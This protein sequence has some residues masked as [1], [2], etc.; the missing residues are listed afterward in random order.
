MP[1]QLGGGSPEIDSTPVPSLELDNYNSSPEFQGS[2]IPIVSTQYSDFESLTG[3]LLAVVDNLSEASSEYS[4]FD[5]DKETIAAADMENLPQKLIKLKQE[6]LD[7]ISDN[8]AE[9]ILVIDGG[10]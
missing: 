6:I 10:S 3:W 5:S 1:L 9:E 7:E 2:K 8:P 4:V